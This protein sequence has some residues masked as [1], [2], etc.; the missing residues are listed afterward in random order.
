MRCQPIS[1][2]AIDDAF[3]VDMELCDAAGPA[4]WRELAALSI[5]F[6]AFSDGRGFTLARRLRSEF[7]FAGAIIATGDVI[8]DQAD[9]LR[10][11][12][13]SHVEIKAN[14]QSQWQYALQIITTRFQQ[15]VGTPRTRSGP[16][17]RNE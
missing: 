17:D 11:C 12:G 4:P 9:Y 8:P 3:P 2:L 5:A 1:N 14:D 7:G 10:R 16:H 15:A 13:F 6:P